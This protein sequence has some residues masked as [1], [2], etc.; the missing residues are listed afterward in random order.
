M[1]MQ[2]PW[3]NDFRL[4]S[5]FLIIWAHRSPPFAWQPRKR[6]YTQTAL[7][8]DTHPWRG[9]ATLPRFPTQ[10]W[11]QTFSW[12]NLEATTYIKEIA[13]TGS[14]TIQQI[15]LKYLP[16]T[17]CGICQMK[18]GCLNSRGLEFSKFC[19]SSLKKIHSASLLMFLKSTFHIHI[20]IWSTTT[21][22][23]GIP[24]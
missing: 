7:P 20:Y 8:G 1:C 3:G 16:Y 4:F 9:L 12:I 23:F 2:K 19:P 17:R 6:H 5:V 13:Y 11:L 14:L 21:Y 24:T 22:Y 18:G 10:A 15:P